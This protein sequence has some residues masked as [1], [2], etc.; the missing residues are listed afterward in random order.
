MQKRIILASGSKQRKMLLESLG[1]EF[2]VIPSNIDE[3]AIRHSEY[4]SQAENIARAKAE[5]VA[6]QNKGIIIAADNFLVCEG[7]ILEKPIDLEEAKEMMRFQSGK[8][9]ISYTGFCYLDLENSIDYSKCV[10]VASGMRE[11][12]DEEISKYVSSFDVLTWAGGYSPAYNYGM[13]LIT[14]I[15]GSLTALTHGLPMEV[16]IPLLVKSGVQINPIYI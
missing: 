4:K 12:S 2:E 15:Q 5:A 9:F 14:H 6:K 16:L 10:E 3:K 8:D 1:I 13:T 7:K 11:M